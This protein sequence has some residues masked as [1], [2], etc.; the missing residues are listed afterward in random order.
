MLTI[1]QFRPFV[2]RLMQDGQSRKMRQIIDKV[3]E[4]AQLSDAQWAQR[5]PSGQRRADNRIDWA[6]FSF[7]KAG[8]LERTDDSFYVITPAGQAFAQKWQNAA[9]ISEN[10]FTGLPAWDSYQS[11]IK[12]RAAQKAADGPSSAD[13]NDTD[14]ADDA[15]QSPDE[16]AIKAVDEIE[17]QVAAELLERLRGNTPE[18]FEKAVIKVL[19]AMGY[20][21]KERLAEHSGQPHDGGIDGVIKQDPLGIQKIYIQA[22]RYGNGNTVGINEIQSFV[23]A[24]QGNGVERGVFI[25]ASEFTKS[26][27]DYAEKTLLGKV[28]LIDGQHL[29]SLMIR[30]HVGIQTR[31][32]L[33]IIEIDE[34]FFD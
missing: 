29:V 16:A 14:E 26:A 33:E 3:R 12:T 30:Y 1:N 17:N 10:D 32:L 20:G 6:C 19:L 9:A 8:I 22:K 21:G 5:L 23:G 18:F 4:L 27:K 34:E 28:V 11:L 2:L 13:A 7:L 25:T 24:L 15:D 31:Q